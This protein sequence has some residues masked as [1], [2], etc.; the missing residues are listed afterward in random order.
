M[1]ICS[2]LGQNLSEMKVTTFVRIQRVIW[3]Q[4]LAS[5]AEIIQ[6]C[7]V[8]IPNATWWINI[9]CYAVFSVFF[10]SFSFLSNRSHFFRLYHIRK[11]RKRCSH[12]RYSSQGII[13][14]FFFWPKRRLVLYTFVQS[15]NDARWQKKIVINSGFL[16]FLWIVKM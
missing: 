10:L 6:L 11:V 16:W 12:S 9:V 1:S 15:S 14:G 2:K 3:D 4:L 5:K 8:S 7:F 13:L